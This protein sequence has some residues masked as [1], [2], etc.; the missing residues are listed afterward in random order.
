MADS[1]SPATLFELLYVFFAFFHMLRV[2]YDNA[3]NLLAYMLNR[4]AEWASQHEVYIDGLHAKGHIGCAAS[5][6]TGVLAPHFHFLCYRVC[7]LSVA[8]GLAT[9]CYL[10]SAVLQHPNSYSVTASMFEVRRYAR[11]RKI[12]VRKCIVL[13]LFAARAMF[14]IGPVDQI[15]ASW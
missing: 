9:K 7:A 2:I 3:C 8:N 6:D 10:L 12:C 14:H 5:F 13:K 1:E 11:V 4:D 15:N